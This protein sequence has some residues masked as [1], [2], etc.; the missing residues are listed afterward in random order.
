[1]PGG[2]AYYVDTSAQIADEF[3]RAKNRP[4]YASGG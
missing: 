1:M 4:R 3:E 2:T